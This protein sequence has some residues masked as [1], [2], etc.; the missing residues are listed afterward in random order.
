MHIRSHKWLNITII[1]IYNTKHLRISQ[2]FIL[3]YVLT[4][5][6][7]LVIIH[8]FITILRDINITII[9]TDDFP[10]LARLTEDQSNYGNHD[11]LFI[12]LFYRLWY[13][14]ST[15][16]QLWQ[17]WHS[18]IFKYEERDKDSTSLTLWVDRSIDTVVFQSP[19]LVYAINRS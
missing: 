4:H 9:L 19:F 10:C 5:Y 6:S 15:S 16:T 3:L 17:V 12:R 13:V 18:M 14:Q 1:N 8:T 11:T 7:N 2:Y